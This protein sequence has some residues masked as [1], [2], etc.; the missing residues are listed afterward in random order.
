MSS[1]KGR[2]LLMFAV[3]CA[4]CTVWAEPEEALVGTWTNRAYNWTTKWAKII[5][6]EDATGTWYHNTFDPPAA[7]NFPFQWKIEDKGKD[8]AGNTYY[9]I[10]FTFGPNNSFKLLMKLNPN[11]DYL[12]MI[13]GGWNVSVYPSTMNPDDQFYFFFNREGK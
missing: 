2:F 3:I 7:E 12:E 8:G 11:G 9:K 4:A 10:I 1:A 13:T 6:N 5:M